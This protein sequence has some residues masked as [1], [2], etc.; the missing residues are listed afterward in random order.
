[1]LQWWQGERFLPSL[2]VP[3]GHSSGVVVVVPHPGLTRQAASD[4]YN[5]PSLR[6][7]FSMESRVNMRVGQEMQRVLAAAARSVSAPYVLFS[8]GSATMGD[9]KVRPQP[10]G[11]KQASADTDPASFV[12]RPV[13]HCR[14]KRANTVA[15]YVREE[16][17]S[18]I[19]VCAWLLAAAVTCRAN[20][21]CNGCCC[22]W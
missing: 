15:G 8:Q 17:T 3:T 14:G 16:S 6:V 10:A 22:Q 4:V 20:S 1:V 11:I 19:R 12:M 9:S 18:E 13:P 7:L 21:A 5:S 2:K